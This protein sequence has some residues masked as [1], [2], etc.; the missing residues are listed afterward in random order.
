MEINEVELSYLWI[1]YIEINAYLIKTISR[2]LT[3]PGLL[4]L[5]Y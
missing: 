2:L 1:F 4:H 3:T 5:H